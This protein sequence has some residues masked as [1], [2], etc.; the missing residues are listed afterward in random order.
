MPSNSPYLRFGP[1]KLNPTE[2][3]LLRGDREIHLA[4][5]LFETLLFLVQNAGHL[6]EKKT[7]MRSVWKESL[8]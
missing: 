1:F 6:V 3:L 2:R 7:L 5:K 8:R 4:S